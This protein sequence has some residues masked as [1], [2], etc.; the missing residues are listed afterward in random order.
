MGSSQTRDQTHVPCIGRRILNHCTTGE[1]LQFLFFVICVCFLKNTSLYQRPFSTRSRSNS[2]PAPGGLHC[3]VTSQAYMFKGEILISN[4]RHFPAT[5]SPVAQ[6]KHLWAI[7]SASLFFIQLFS[8]F[9]WPYLQNTFLSIHFSSSS[10]L[11]QRS[12]KFC[13]PHLEHQEHFPNLSFCFTP[14]L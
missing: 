14:V 7:L 1:V 12:L 8:K 3:R 6:A 10:V 13:I 5:S 2:A 11:S 9:Y 4:F